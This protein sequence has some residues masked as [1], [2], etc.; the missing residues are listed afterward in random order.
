LVFL[1]Y[2]FITL[3]LFGIILL[4]IFKKDGVF[5]KII[6]N[7]FLIFAPHF[8]VLLYF[9]NQFELKH[10]YPLFLKVLLIVEIVLFIAYL[11]LKVNIVPYFNKQINSL[12][13]NILMGGRRLVLYSLYTS[14]LQLFI[15]YFALQFHSSYKITSY[16]FVLD[17][18]VML[19]FIVT[20]YLNGMLRI[21]FT[22]RRLNIFMKVLLV[23]TLYIPIINLL[24]ILY[25]SG[26][27]KS[28][29]EHECFRVVDQNMRID[30]AICKTKYPLVLIHGVGFKD[31]KYINYWGRIPKEL[32]RNGA[33][34]YYGNQEAW[35]TVEYNAQDIKDKILDIIS[36]TECE[37]VNIIAHSK[38]GLDARY[39]I[40]NLNM[41]EYVASLTSI[42]VPHRGSKVIDVIYKIPKGIY[43]VIGGGFN[44]YYR[45]IGDKNPDFF[46]ASR[47]LSTYYSKE[48]NEAVKDD[49]QVYYQS[50]ASIMKHM[51]SDYILTIPYFILKLT[52][53]ENDGLV[54]VES[55]KWGEFKGVL[56]N[57]Y[58]RGISHGDQ[59]DLRKSDYKG[60]DVRK[61]YMD[62][63]EDLKTRGY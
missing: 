14:F 30:S 10:K 22:S 28:E 40:S 6:I 38:G 15:Y 42:A 8:C 46:T 29:Y 57:K 23:S 48:F 34:I 21:I 12:R 54:E 52:S 60:F 26:V 41:G 53:G 13:V 31:F 27:A 63:V 36:K 24:E 33:T 5:H 4:D 50:Y 47:Q 56:K 7:L 18:I 3:F 32:I 51:F 11:F 20:L 1:I 2:L 45:K 37:K 25:V 9:L 17:L 39:M 59:I 19:L 62:I 61:Q 55:A 44:K 58:S 49:V 35:G 16:M 43:K